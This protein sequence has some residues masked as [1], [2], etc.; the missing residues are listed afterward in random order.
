MTNA[1]QLAAGWYPDPS[2]AAQWRWWDGAAWTGD[3]APMQSQQQAATVAPHIVGGGAAAVAQAPVQQQPAANAGAAWQQPTYIIAQQGLFLDRTYNISL[4]SQ[5]GAPAANK[6]GEGTRVAQVQRKMVTLKER[7]RFVDPSGAEA[8][9]IQSQK[10]MNFGARYIVT[11]AAGAPIAQLKKEQ[12]KSLL[13]ST[14]SVYDPSGTHQVA[15]AREASAVFA[16]LRRLSDLASLFPY[17]F[18]IEAGSAAPSAG[19][20]LGT[21]RRRWGFRDRYDLDL[22]AD[23]SMLLDRRVAVALGLTLDAL[24]RR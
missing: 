3:V 9:G 8:I 23:Q 21:F 4:P 2:N 5:P 19:Q 16:V 22:S 12:M 24:Q 7:I 15:V 6:H 1:P 10:L 11:D 14:W 13:R 17:H 18:T 20:A